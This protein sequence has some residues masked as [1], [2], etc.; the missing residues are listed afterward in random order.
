MLQQVIS[1]QDF[2]F[3][4]KLIQ[5]LTAKD[6]NVA[7]FVE[8]FFAYDK[9]ESA[10]NKK[11]FEK[12]N[13]EVLVNQ[14][15]TQNKGI[16][17][18]DATKGN[19]AAL[20]SENT[21]T[22]TTGHQLNLLSGPLYSIYKVAQ[23]INITRDLNSK[24]PNYNF[25]PVFWMATEDHDFEEINHINLFKD[26]LAWNHEDVENKVAGRIS[27]K[28]ISSFIEAIKAKFSNPEDLEKLSP[29]FDSISQAHDLADAT[30]TLMNHFFGE[31][32][33]VIID[34]DDTELKGLFA[35]VV[36]REIEEQVTFKAVSKINAQLLKKD[37]HN[38]VF[39]RNSNI[40]LIQEDGKR[41]RISLEE[42]KWAVGENEISQEEL[43]TRLYSSPEAFSPNALL[44][45]V[46][47]ETILPNLAYVGGGGEIAYW[48]QL[49]GVFQS[50][51]LAFPM[52]IAR[53]SFVLLREREIEI[54]NDSGLELKQL[55]GDLNL[56]FK[57]KVKDEI[58]GSIII[59]DIKQALEHEKIKALK[60]AE[61]IDKGAVQSIES[62]FTRALN[63]FEKLENKLVKSVK[64]KDEN[65]I[66]KLEKLKEK[67]FPNGGFQERHENI[68]SYLVNDSE[69]IEKIIG[70]YTDL[71]SPKINV[72]QL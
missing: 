58:G 7:E 36:K 59:D 69:I 32:G 21:F 70:Y 52:I 64:N 17:I 38:Q 48:M 20:G 24:F 54:L 55:K 19:I 11:V 65:R 29:I 6:P 13:R 3:S 28:G 31:H 22:I 1:F 50:L 14:L 66:R 12:S 44:R 2:G 62:T 35:P 33:L 16:N 39:L 57:D 60:K 71:E 40:F 72:I 34:G 68:I 47:Q 37:Y 46:Y 26:N 4:S 9:I 56:L 8:E 45:P 51:G 23:V 30:R 43:L 63:D 5:N 61:E 53:D 41:E 10:I 67:I 18:S 42:G 27:T 49:K 15:K 25:V